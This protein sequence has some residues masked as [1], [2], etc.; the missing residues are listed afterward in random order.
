VLN[1]I[2][3]SNKNLQISIVMKA[4]LS[5]L[6]YKD[7]FNGMDY[8]YLFEQNQERKEKANKNL[9]SKK[10]NNIINDIKLEVI[11]NNIA[12]TTHTIRMK[13]QYPGL[14]T[15]IGINH[16]ASIE[17]E[18]KLGMHFD[19]TYGMPVVYGSSVKGLLRSA[20]PE[21]EIKMK[22]NENTK[23]KKARE[24]KNKIRECKIKMI[25]SY[26]GEKFSDADIDALKE[27]IFDG[28]KGKRKITVGK[29]AIEQIEYFS[30]YE[31][32]IFFDAVIIAPNK[33]GKILDSDSIT[34]HGDNPLKNPNPITFLKIASGVTMEFRFDLKD[35]LFSAQ[36]KEDLFRKILLD[37]GI[38]AK[39]NV[40]YGQFRR[41]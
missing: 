40:G 18:F 19:Y 5:W 34:P 6:F 4:N 11:S 8:N 1:C 33:K 17:G 32:D 28:V 14:V 22:V 13:I 41:E 23:E 30:I 26:M 35:N 15:G 3:A 16:E 37:F 39:T 2:E 10:H 25:R 36:Q 20:F 29:K 38:G 31:R 24:N 7:Y 27:E 21:K 9:L 12:N